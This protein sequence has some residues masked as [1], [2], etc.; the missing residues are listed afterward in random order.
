MKSIAVWQNLLEMSQ[1]SC[2]GHVYTEHKPNSV[3]HYQRYKIRAIFLTCQPKK[4]F[5][6]VACINIYITDL[7]EI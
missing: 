3:S 2:Q 6:F 7:N 1:E 5:T 4:P